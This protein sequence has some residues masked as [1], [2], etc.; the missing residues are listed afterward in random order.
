MGGRGS[1]CLRADADHDSSVALQPDE[2]FRRFLRTLGE[3]P[4]PFGGSRELSA[5]CR[6]LSAD[7]ETLR[8][9]PK[10]CGSPH[11]W[12]NRRSIAS[13]RG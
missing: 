6:E 1:R 2:I 13:L 10:P 7:A 9:S 4:T 11:T 5:S 12:P 8:E 3:L